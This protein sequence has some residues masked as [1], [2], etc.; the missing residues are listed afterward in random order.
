MVDDA[1]RADSG[2]GK[3]K[4]YRRAKAAGTDHQHLG[5][6]E[7]VLSWPADFMQHDVACIAF[8]LVVREAPSAGS[9][10]TK[11][12]GATR[13]FIECRNFLQRDPRNRRNH[14]LRNPVAAGNGKIVLH[15]D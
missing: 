7:L 9:R 4:Q 14:H 11:A 15:H 13:R 8:D 2:G 3:I 1:D 12:T 10:R 6:L 5:R